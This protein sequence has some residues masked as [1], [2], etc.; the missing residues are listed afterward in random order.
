MTPLQPGFSG[1]PL[2]RAD[3][4]RNDSAALGTLRQHAGARALRL[5]G[6]IPVLSDDGALIWD[7]IDQIAPDAPLILLGLD[8][9]RPHFVPLGDDLGTAPLMRSPQLMSAL[10]VLSPGALALFGTARSLLDWHTRHRFCGRCGSA[11]HYARSGWARTCSACDQT[12]FPRVDPVVI[13]LA[14]YD[15]RALVGR[16][17]SWPAGRYSAL[18]GF[19]EP[20]ETIEEAVAR[21]LYEE[22]GVVATSVRYITSQPWP[23]PAQLML[24]CIAPVESD[25]LT[26]APAEIEDAR[27]VT[28]DEVRA[29]L[30][31][32]PDAVFIAPPRYAVAHALLTAWAQL[33]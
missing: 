18:A 22:A 5:D 4:M 23:F 13:M 10:A 15:G 12:H 24:A 27:W 8:D 28:R 6:L 7:P 17:P 1:Y 31:H 2:N 21:E 26:L 32:A 14:E 9:D 29:A 16:A 11:T 33:G 19:L 3:D 25:A 20:G 30:D